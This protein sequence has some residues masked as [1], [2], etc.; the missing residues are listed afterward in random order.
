MWCWWWRPAARAGSVAALVS[1]SAHLSQPS[2]LPGVPCSTASARA[3]SGPASSE[4]LAAIRM[5]A[6]WGC[7]PATPALNLPSRHLGLFPAHE[8]GRRRVQPEGPGP[9]LA[10]RHLDL[11]R[12]LP[13]LE[14]PPN[15]GPAGH[16]QVRF[17]WC[18]EKQASP[19]LKPAGR[20]P[21][22][23]AKVPAG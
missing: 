7:C 17:R 15:P 20:S 13:L 2:T 9:I 22:A 8:L 14:P 4:A 23:N 10:E 16:S 12:L 21:K 1:A 11:G 18:P 3:T 5:P 6:R 19:Q